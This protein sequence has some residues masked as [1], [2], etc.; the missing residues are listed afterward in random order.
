MLI[1]LFFLFLLSLKTFDF[2][3]FTTSKFQPL[4]KGIWKVRRN[5]VHGVKNDDGC[6]TKNNENKGVKTTKE[7]PKDLTL[8]GE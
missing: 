4:C 2:D 8:G 1:V 7:D 6:T 3:N 5:T